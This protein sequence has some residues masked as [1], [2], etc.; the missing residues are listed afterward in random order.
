M[1]GVRLY[2]INIF[3]TGP[4][5][6]FIIRNILHIIKNLSCHQSSSRTWS[7]LHV[8]RFR[9]YIVV[10]SNFK[11][12]ISSFPKTA[13]SSYNAH[14]RICPKNILFNIKWG[15]RTVVFSED[16]ISLVLLSTEYK[17]ASKNFS[18]KRKEIFRSSLFLIFA[19]SLYSTSLK[20]RIVFSEGRWQ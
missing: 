1:Q 20:L 5:T 8:W 6:L 4:K 9:Y 3:W 17:E 16:P 19:L 2:I 11:S 7:S 13:H 15:L 18:D 12:E 10:P 14:V